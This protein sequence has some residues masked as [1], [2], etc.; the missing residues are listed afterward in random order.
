MVRPERITV[1]ATAADGGVASV[2]ATVTDLVFQ[3]PV[4]RYELRLQD[5]HTR[6]R[7]HPRPARR[8]AHPR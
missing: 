2:Q 4:V 5:G 1:D 3:G 7:P 8:V 6:H